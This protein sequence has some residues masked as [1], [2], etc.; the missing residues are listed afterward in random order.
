M[1]E[2]EGGKE[3]EGGERGGGEELPPR[4][5]LP[6]TLGIQACG[7]LGAAGKAPQC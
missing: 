5:H 1:G 7:Q 2:E 6:L 4:L 3:G